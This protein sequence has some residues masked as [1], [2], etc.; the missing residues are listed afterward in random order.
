M[1]FIFKKDLFLNLKSAIEVVRIRQE[2]SGEKSFPVLID[3]GGITG[4]D[5]KAREYFVTE[6][7]QRGMSAAA[8]LSNSF[9]PHFSPI[10]F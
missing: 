4:I 1:F 9:L 3:S 10:F 5:K 7:A 6:K 2:I 8:L